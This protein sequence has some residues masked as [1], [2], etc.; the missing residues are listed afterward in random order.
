M[1]YFYPSGIR[2]YRAAK[3]ESEEGLRIVTST[4]PN[5]FVIDKS[6]GGEVGKYAV[7]DPEGW[8][9]VLSPEE[10]EERYEPFHA[11]CFIENVWWET[12]TE[13]NTRVQAIQL[14]YTTEAVIHQG[15][16]SWTLCGDPGDWLVTLE[17]A[18][19]QVIMKDSAFRAKY[20]EE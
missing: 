9:E 19:I 2:H 12:Y 3:I 20:E 1:P 14:L 5:G 6:V 8:W 7:L 15:T 18:N 10:L 4:L 11:R 17:H 13:R 16:K